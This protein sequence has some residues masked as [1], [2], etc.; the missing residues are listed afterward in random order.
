[1]IG[2]RAY[3]AP[4]SQICIIIFALLA[5]F[6]FKATGQYRSNLPPDE[7]LRR[8]LNSQLKVNIRG[9]E[10]IILQPPG[11]A[12]MNTLR[13]VVRSAN[14]PVVMRWLEPRTQQGTISLDDGILCK[15]YNPTTSI[16]HVSRSPAH[17]KTAVDVER[18]LRH[19]LRNYKVHLEDMATMAGRNCFV[20]QL[21]PYHPMSHTKRIWVDAANWSTLG[22]SESNSRGNTTGVGT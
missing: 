18:C 8:N 2:L 17:P 10:R 5:T 1:M 21:S 6:S 9:H 7:I 3:S 19:I 13:E 4:S 15:A 16:V 11:Q 22:Q 12:M 14:G 20:L